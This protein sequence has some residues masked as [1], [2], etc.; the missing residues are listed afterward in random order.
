MSDELVP[1]FDINKSVN[2]LFATPLVIHDWPNSEQFNK[3]FEELIRNSEKED[4][5]E[6][7]V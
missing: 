2:M 7:L 5:H 3:D 4:K 1:D 6:S